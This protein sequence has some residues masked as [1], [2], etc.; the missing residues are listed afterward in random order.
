MLEK[1]SRQAQ[2]DVAVADTVHK[3][4]SVKRYKTLACPTLKKHKPATNLFT[5][6]TLTR[7]CFFFFGSF[8]FFS[9]QDKR[10]K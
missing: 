8:S 4:L 9:S 6:I 10:K 7:L 2:A 3:A 5:D 1:S